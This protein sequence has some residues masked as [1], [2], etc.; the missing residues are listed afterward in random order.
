[1]S[2]SEPLGD[3]DEAAQEAAWREIIANFG[4]RAELPEDEIAPAET[5]ARFEDD[6]DESFERDGDDYETY[7]DEERFVA[8]RPSLPR[9]TPGRFLAWLG[10]L[11]APVAAVL[12]F[13]VHVSFGWWIPTWVIDGL[14]IAFLAGFGYL[15]LAM[16]REPRDPWDDGARL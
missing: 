13:V 5:A 16:P 10:A 15:V 9:T 8:P 6:V 14:V 12:L 1:M 7:E 3:P 11:G 2:V 4:D